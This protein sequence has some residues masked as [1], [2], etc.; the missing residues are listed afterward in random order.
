MIHQC[1]SIHSRK[2]SPISITPN[3]TSKRKPTGGNWC[4]SILRTQ[5]YLFPFWFSETAKIIKIRIKTRDDSSMKSRATH[6]YQKNSDSDNQTQL[7]GLPDIEMFSQRQVSNWTEKTLDD[8]ELRWTKNETLN[9]PW[10]Q[11]FLSRTRS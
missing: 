3:C 11:V 5:W 10:I 7:S 1:I 2:F 8:F 6:K 9:E 4:R